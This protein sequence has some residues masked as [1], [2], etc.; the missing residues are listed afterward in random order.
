MEADVHNCLRQDFPEVLDII[1]TT[2]HYVDHKVQVRLEILVDQDL[3]IRQAS[4]I[5]ERIEK[6]VPQRIPYINEVDIHLEV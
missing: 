3:T 5:A 4:A 2:V 6:I 1:H